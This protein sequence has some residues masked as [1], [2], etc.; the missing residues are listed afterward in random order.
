MTAVL[1]P[2]QAIFDDPALAGDIGQQAAQFA[3][4]AGQIGELLQHPPGGFDQLL[5]QLTAMPLPDLP[6]PEGFGDALAGVL[7]D[8]QEGLGSLLPGLLDAIGAVEHDITQ[9]LQDALK[10]LLETIARVGTVF[11]GDPSCG[12]VAGFAPPAPNPPDGNPPAPPPA[13]AAAQVAAARAQIATLPADLTVRD[14]L[15]WVHGKVKDWRPA[16][17]AFRAIPLIDDLRDPLDS[18]ARWDALDGDGLVQEF[19]QTLAALA[20]IVRS[21]TQT[22]VG[23]ALPAAAIGVLPAA[24]GPAARALATAL[25]A[26]RSAIQ[27]QDAAAIA[28]QLA[29]AQAA[30]AQIEAANAAMDAQTAALE[31][32]QQGIARLPGQLETAIS[33]LLVLLS[34]PT[35]WADLSAP[36]GELPMPL[37]DDSFAPLTELLGRVQETLEN[38]LGLLDV[39]QVTAPLA[40]VLTQAQAAI[41]TLD[42]RIVQLTAA[43]RAQFQQASQ[44]LQA[45]DVD[46]LRQQIEQ[47]IGNAGADIQQGISELLQPA[48][49][50]L[51][52]ALG[53]AAA[54]VDG[55]DPEQLR[56]PVEDAMAAI[57]A[58][59]QGAALEP[60]L[61]ALQ[62]LSDLVATLDEL[63]FVPV[64][65]LVIKGIGEVKAALDSIDDSNLSPPMPDMIDAAMSVL[66]ASLDPLTAPLVGEVRQLVEQGPMAVLE[67]VRALPALIAEQLAQFSPRALLAAPLEQ[68]YARLLA[69]LDAFEPASWLDAA[70]GQL[71]G[72]RERLADALDIARLLA[73]L[74][75]THGALL[76][77]LQRFS[78]AQ[79]VAPVTQRLDQVRAGLQGALPT[80]AVTAALD[81]AIA[82][83]RG[84]LQPVE[85]SLA[86][87]QDLIER[88]G[89]L[90]DPRGQLDAWLADI[91]GKLPSSAPATLAAALAAVRAA[92]DAAQAAP[93]RAAYD[94]ARQPLAEALATAGASD[95]LAGITAA[96][97]RLA[98]TPDAPPEVST[99]LATLQPLDPAFSRGLRA[100]AR[101]QTALADTDAGMAALLD[102][103]DARYLRPDGP[104]AGLVPELQTLDQW[105]THLLGLIDAQLGAPVVLLCRQLFVLSRLLQSFEAATTALLTAVN[106]KIA[107][108]LAAPQALAGLGQAVQ[109]VVERVLAVDIGLFARETDALHQQLLAQLRALDPQTLAAPLRDQLAQ[110]LEALTLDA[111]FTP[112]LRQAL[113]QARAVLTQKL[114]GVDPAPLLIEPLQ[115]RY[116]QTILPL[117][118]SFDVGPSIATLADWFEALP[119]QLEAE[120]ER[121]DTAYQELLRAAP[122]GAGASRSLSL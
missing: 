21:S 62:N 114:A 67:Q 76:T 72:L 36:L 4:L 111:V 54:A 52:S 65:D 88:L 47:V 2:L 41:G 10:P 3:G 43:A 20:Q 44:A 87:A 101:L 84:L 9:G 100:L 16:A 94:G 35:T 80:A 106:A 34:P 97:S 91:L 112:A 19:E 108:I 119:G 89:K 58:A 64:A 103:W 33:R 120:L 28:T 60:L 15:L 55:F 1:A 8:L 98:G 63:S 66:P 45:L 7:P 99:W 42:A 23:A 122:G 56:Q 93:L 90:T 77:E 30:Q 13:L 26:L 117:A 40:Q 92:V 51:S 105:R 53:A 5:Q 104:L 57:E 32:L 31:A 46:G 95:T 83:I 12:L 110:V 50:A 82:R 73:P 107:E 37:A 27:A 71:D 115:A 102:Q 96:R 22:V 116:E 39:S 118:Q 86:V 75:D 74:R 18:L 61:S 6:V 69:A 24:L 29:A 121:V 48:A 85:A 68:P 38:L 81:Q 17:L 49:D 109:Q 11:A 14:L 25:D 59:L 70:D 79:L 78:A 113:D